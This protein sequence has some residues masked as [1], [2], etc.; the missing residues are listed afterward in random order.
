MLSITTMPYPASLER[1]GIMTLLASS[2]P[3]ILTHPSILQGNGDAPLY[4]GDGPRVD[5]GFGDG[6]TFGV[7]IMK[8]DEV[9]RMTGDNGNDPGTDYSEIVINFDG[10]LIYSN[11]AGH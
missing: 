10:W 8:G 1:S 3:H 2:L 6:D 7:M 11:S 5:G 4:Q 9:T